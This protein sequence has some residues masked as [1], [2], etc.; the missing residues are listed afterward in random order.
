[1]KNELS[2]VDARKILNLL[3]GLTL[4]Q[5]LAAGA[6]DAASKL[7]RIAVGDKVRVIMEAEP[8]HKVAGIK[9]LRAMTGSGLTEAKDHYERYDE[10]SIGRPVLVAV[11][12]AEEAERM[13]IEA[14][15]TGVDVYTEVHRD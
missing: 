2:S 15:G 12:S 5:L 1:M 11:V 13:M 4:D 6:F 8:G 3:G 14:R 10:M 7:A 9:A